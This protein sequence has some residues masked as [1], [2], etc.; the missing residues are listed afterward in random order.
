MQQFTVRVVAQQLFKF[1]TSQNRVHSNLIVFNLFLFFSFH[2]AY[3]PQIPGKIITITYLPMM[4][5]LLAVSPYCGSGNGG[6][7]RAGSHPRWHFAQAAIEG[8]KFGILAFA[9]QC[10]SISLYLFLIYSVHRGCT[11]PVGGAAPR[12]FAPGWQRPSCHHCLHS[13]VT[14]SMHH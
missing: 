3:L 8:R 12:T 7:G 14:G 2:Q 9:L 5:T 1:T 10:V 13:L 11:L 6:G 4:W